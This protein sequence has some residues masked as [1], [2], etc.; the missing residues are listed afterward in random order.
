MKVALLCT[1]KTAGYVTQL[2]ALKLLYVLPSQ[3]KVK[4]SL[5]GFKRK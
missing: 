1:G 4:F 3:Y 2:A 5:D